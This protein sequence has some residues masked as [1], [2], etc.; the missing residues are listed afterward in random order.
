[1]Q[2]TGD[3]PLTFRLRWKDAFQGNIPELPDGSPARKEKK[4]KGKS[5]G[6]SGEISARKVKFDQ[7][8]RQHEES[9]IFGGGLE[10]C[11]DRDCFSFWNLD[12]NMQLLVSERKKMEFGVRFQRPSNEAAVASGKSAGKS[13]KGKKK[14]K[15]SPKRNDIEKLNYCYVAVLELTLGSSL[16]VQDF[17]VIS[18]LK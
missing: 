12:E 3:C 10:R 4:K 7:V 6:K 2:N 11:L 13:T 15:E 8:L 18:V 5:D 17:V 1:I 16:L 9:A 14:R